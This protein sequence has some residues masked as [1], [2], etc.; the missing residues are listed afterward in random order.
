[1]STVFAFIIIICSKFAESF[2]KNYRK[3]IAKT[4]KT[5]KMSRANTGV[6]QT[7]KDI[8]ERI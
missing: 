1:M 3:T 4:E 7:Y 8:L 2:I 6:Q 5:A